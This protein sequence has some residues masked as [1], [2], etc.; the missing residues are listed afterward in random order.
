MNSDILSPIDAAARTNRGD[1]SD[2]A[3][4]KSSIVTYSP[5]DLQVFVHGVSSTSHWAQSQNTKIF[6]LVV[7]ILIK[8]IIYVRDI[9]YPKTALSFR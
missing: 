2:D 4:I 1:G 6:T 7:H 3:K 5:R 8:Q 9:P